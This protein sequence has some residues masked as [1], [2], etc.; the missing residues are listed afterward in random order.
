MRRIPTPIG[1]LLVLIIVIVLAVVTELVKQ[2]THLFSRATPAE[3]LIVPLSVANV[4][5]TSLT[6]YW[7]S[8]VT[9]PGVVVY[10]LSPTSLDKVATDRNSSQIHFIQV[11]GLKPGTTYYFRL[12]GQDNA[13]LKEVTT[14]VSSPP[15]ADP[16]FG[17]STPGVIA[18]W[19]RDGFP[20][21]KIAALTKGDG[22]YVLP[23]YGI[24]AGQKEKITFYSPD[25]QASINCVAG[26]DK[27]LPTVEI[28][29]HKDC[30]AEEGSSL[31]TGNSRTTGFTIP[32]S[33]PSSIATG[34]TL[35]IDLKD[36]EVVSTS[37]PTISGKAG[38]KQVVKIQI[39][40]TQNFSGT[41]VADI[42][43]N[44]SWTPPVKLLP[45]KYR[46]TATTTNPDGA[47]QTVTRNFTVPPRG[48]DILPPTSGTPS[49]IL[50]HKVC[51]NHACIVVE[52]QGKDECAS[53]ADCRPITPPSSPPPSSDSS[54]AS[55]A[56]SLPSSPS[57]TV[58]APP[59]TGILENTLLILAGGLVL[60]TI[61]V[62]L[63]L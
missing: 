11:S 8:T 54:L 6:F 40:L 32:D 39:S 59:P 16:I 4:T 62:G 30:T 5:D 57:A 51:L 53:D 58:I 18:V 14:K 25:G 56:T 29:E 44:W 46:V 15:T 2:N 23:V 7:I 63:I 49:A 50:T 41:V 27:P 17:K 43:G 9:K 10:G 1:L 19:E 26:K 47:T 33:Q 21:D 42:A 60:I 35:T 48:V 34:G 28:G 3:E 20:E 31:Y 37:L 13:S 22:S 38:P 52:G 55:R 36:Q 61:G 45:G 12:D 24:V